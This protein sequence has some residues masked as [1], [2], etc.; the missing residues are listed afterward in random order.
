[1]VVLAALPYFVSKKLHDTLRQKERSEWG[2][3]AVKWLLEEN[4][5][6]TINRR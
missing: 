2:M 3:T 6:I 5:K 1:V 4:E